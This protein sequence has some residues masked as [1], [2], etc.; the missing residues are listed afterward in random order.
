MSHANQIPEMNDRLTVLVVTDVFWPQRTGGISKSLLTEVEGLVDRGHEVV[1]I[2]RKVDS[3]LPDHEER[4]GYDLFRYDSPPKDRIYYQLYPLYSVYRLGSLVEELHR[5]Y[6]F[7]V[8]YVH[9]PFQAAGLS[10]AAAD[11]PYANVFHAPTPREIELDLERGKYGWKAPFAQLVNGLIERTEAN[12]LE[13]ANSVIVRSEFMQT[14]L[15]DRYERIDRSKVERIPL[16]VDTDRFAFREDPRKVREEIGLPTDRPI[17]LTVRRLVARMGIENLIKSI[18]SVTEQYPDVL[19]AIGGKGYLRSKL[20]STAHSQGVANNV[21]FLGFIPEEDLPKYYGAADIF[22]MPTEQLEGFGLST[23]ESLS[24]GTPVV[25]TPVGA[26]PE[27]IGGLDDEL[28]SAD[29]SVESLAHSISRWL[30]NA[31]VD[32][33]H[34]CRAYAESEFAVETVVPRITNHFQELVEEQSTRPSDGP[35]SPR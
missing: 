25:G 30:Q 16:C 11:F 5:Q 12:Q 23:I 31:S 28:L 27:V 35:Q 24:C 29:A 7:D 17:V 13:E 2:T 34:R 20:E 19:L 21:E 32:L 4:P 1:V 3:E 10:R 6:D 15:F 33:R 26:N 18:A 14:Q 8:G 22:A 9:N